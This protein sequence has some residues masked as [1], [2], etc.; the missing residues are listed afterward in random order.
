MIIQIYLI[1]YLL[2]LAFRLYYGKITF[3]TNQIIVYFGYLLGLILSIIAQLDIIYEE[4]IYS[5]TYAGLQQQHLT[6]NSMIL[7]SIS[8]TI[9]VIS[10][11]IVMNTEANLLASSRGFELPLPLSRTN[12]GWEI[13]KTGG[14]EY[15]L[16]FGTIVKKLPSL[17][18][19]N[20]Y[21][22]YATN[23]PPRST[24][25]SM[26]PSYQH[27]QST[28][29]SIGGGGNTSSG[30]SSLLLRSSEKNKQKNHT[31]NNLLIEVKSMEQKEIE[32]S[33]IN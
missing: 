5:N 14:C 7:W 23:I 26:K 30:I 20:L 10:E 2:H 16:L 3:A 19:I 9:L 32:M 12:T 11:L 13:S 25:T 18:Y 33:T 31:N 4:H 1:I 27:Y 15:S 22:E 21:G 24:F 17:N 28:S 29:S 6:F 8:I